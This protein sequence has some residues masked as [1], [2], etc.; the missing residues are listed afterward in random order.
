MSSRS[1]VF[2]LF[3]LALVVFAA[4][5]ALPW[6]IGTVTGDPGIA[7]RAWETQ[8]VPKTGMIIFAIA[9]IAVSG[10]GFRAAGFQRPVGKGWVWRS[11][12]IGALIGGITT[13]LIRAT[14]AR[15]MT[16]L[17]QLGFGGIVLWV[18]FYSSI[19]EEIFVRGWFQSAL[20]FSAERR[21]TVFR[22]AFSVPVLASGILF[23]MLHLSLL[24]RGVDGWTVA[25]TVLATTLLGLLAAD[26]RE[27]FD[28][29]LP[30]VVAHV[31]FNVGG[32]VAAILTVI[33]TMVITGHPPAL[34]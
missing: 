6:L 9:A 7:T 31:A 33:L 19:A 23:G 22:K 25:I 3:A 17:R 11:I 21:V 2:V 26:L 8:F 15:G 12:L 18:W 28:S 24:V 5:A 14:P 32:M 13:V 27:R 16:F 20:A 29:L 30:P 4:L 10:S 34:G 1:R